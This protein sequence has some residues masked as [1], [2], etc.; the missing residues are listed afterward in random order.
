MSSK[1]VKPSFSV[2]EFME[3]NDADVIEQR[4]EIEQQRN[5]KTNKKRSFNKNNHNKNNENIIKYPFQV[6]P[7]PATQIG[8]RKRDGFKPTVIPAFKRFLSKNL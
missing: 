6:P 5:N 7:T 8:L 2:F 4:Q 3:S 1:D